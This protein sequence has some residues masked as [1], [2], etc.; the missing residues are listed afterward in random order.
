MQ[1]RQE[2]FVF[3]FDV[4]TSAG[5]VDIMQRVRLEPRFPDN[6][7]VITASRNG[8]NPWAGWNKRWIAP[9][10]NLQTFRLQTWSTNEKNAIASPTNMR[11]DSRIVK[12]LELHDVYSNAQELRNDYKKRHLAKSLHVEPSEFDHHGTYD[13]LGG[14]R[15]RQTKRTKR[16]KSTRKRRH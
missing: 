16:R 13:I 9:W 12:I 14:R 3:T 15:R 10:D 5:S 4:P 2:Q 7:G 8:S 6:L 1:Q 11:S